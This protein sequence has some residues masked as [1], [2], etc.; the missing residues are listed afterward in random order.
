MFPQMAPKCFKPPPPKICG[1]P[2]GPP[3]TAPRFKLR[4]GRH[5]AY[6]LRGV[7]LEIA[8]HKIIVCHGFHDSKEM[9]F[10]F[11]QQLLEELSV[12]FVIYDR[13]GYGESD[14]NPQRS[15][16]NE[17]L[18]VEELADHLKLGS[19]FYVIGLSIGAYVGWSCLMYIPHRLSGISLVAP[20][21]NYYWPGFPS[22]LANKCFKRLPVQDQWSIR[23]AHYAPWLFY[24]FM[25]QKL[26]PTFKTGVNEDMFTKEDLDIFKNFSNNPNFASLEAK[27]KQQGEFYCLYQDLLTGYGKW[28]QGPLDVKNPFPNNEGVVHLWQAGEDKVVPIELTRYIAEKQPW[29]RYHELERKGH[30]F[31]HYPDICEGFLREILGE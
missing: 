31:F 21:F 11:C 27:A 3:V 13:P 30:M 14:P 25:T 17:A 1:S 5:M 6:K 16:K 2:D 10:P 28:E 24:W 15:P 18:D 19:R 22:K 9:S 26:I 7:E 4:D 23:I 20:F 12:C 29:I 8:K